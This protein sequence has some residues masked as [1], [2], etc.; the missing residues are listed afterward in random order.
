MH[1]LLAARTLNDR[2]SLSSNFDQNVAMYYRLAR[3]GR[4]DIV[5]LLE[6]SKSIHQHSEREAIQGIIF[7]VLQQLI[8]LELWIMLTK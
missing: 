8:H 5:Q 2:L 3:A 4:S 1:A 7:V 6:E